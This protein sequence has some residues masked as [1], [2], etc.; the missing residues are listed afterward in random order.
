MRFVKRILFNV[1]Y[2]DAILLMQTFAFTFRT[3]K[4]ELTCKFCFT[5]P[6]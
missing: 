2:K 6:R 3:R 5:E 1:A 4:R